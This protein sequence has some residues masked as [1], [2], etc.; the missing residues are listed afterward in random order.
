MFCVDCG[1]DK[2]IFRNG[3]CLKCYL[4]THQFSKGPEFIDI[5][6]CAH[7]G[8]LKYK[9]LWINDSLESIVEKN[10]KQIFSISNELKEVNIQV[11]CKP[12]PER[13]SCDINVSG[14]LDD[15]LIKEKHHVFIRIKQHSCEVCSKQFGGYHEA[16]IQIRP[17]QRKL[18][19]EKKN[20]IQFFV[21]DL[22]NGI[23]NKGNRSLFLTDMDHEHGGL[24]FFIS[25]KHAAFSI[26][27]KIQERFGGE[28][29]VSTK[30]IGMKDGKQLY[31]DTYLLRFLPFQKNDIF[32]LDDDYF[33]VLNIKGTQLHVVKLKN[34]SESL[35][36]STDA[37]KGLFIAET[38]ELSFKPILVNETKNELQLMHP[39]NYKIFTLKKPKET[40]CFSEETEIIQINDLFFFKPSRYII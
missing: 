4:K 37:E 25:D 3:S 21:E 19:N 20:E 28:I 29:H 14:K 32:K 24:D 34:W 18:H 13:Q 12:E 36:S 39:I 26:V 10:V 1:E 8:S 2:Q 27:K 40:F 35:I 6:M 15:V 16:I 17:S 31:R 23:R 9:S 11:K 38:D 33:Y 5:T 7:C 22:I 30:N